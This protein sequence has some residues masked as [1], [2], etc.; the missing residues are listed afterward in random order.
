MITTD[1]NKFERMCLLYLETCAVDNGGRVDSSVI[2][3]DDIHAIEEFKKQGLIIYERIPA[4]QLGLKT[5][6][7]THYVEFLDSAWELAHQLRKERAMRSVKVSPDRA[8][9]VQMG[10]IV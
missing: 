2:N 4:L 5:S 6:C 10:K 8:D 3:L 1:M 9:L 7:A